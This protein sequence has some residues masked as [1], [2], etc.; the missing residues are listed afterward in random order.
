MCLRPSARPGWR[1]LT[2]EQQKFC[3]GYLRISPFIAVTSR[4]KEYSSA[5][6]GSISTDNAV[7]RPS[8]LLQA[9]VHLSRLRCECTW[10]L[11]VLCRCTRFRVCEEV[12]CTPQSARGAATQ[13]RWIYLR[14]V[15]VDRRLF[16]DNLWL[17]VRVSRTLHVAT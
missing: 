5:T 3:P 11:Q 15:P 16:D 17:N 13:V 14:S 4:R 12:E 6:Q 10:S 1:L 8:C 2:P 9:C 7:P